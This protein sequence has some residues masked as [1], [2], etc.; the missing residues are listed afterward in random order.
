M[1][2]EFLK[3]AF[4]KLEKLDK[5]KEPEKYSQLLKLIRMETNRQLEACLLLK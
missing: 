1:N 3:L 2:K 5:E 4:E